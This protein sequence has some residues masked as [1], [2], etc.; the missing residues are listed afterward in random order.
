M[1]QHSEERAT[2][3]EATV[4]RGFTVLRAASLTLPAEESIRDFRAPVAPGRDIRS[5]LFGGF[6]RCV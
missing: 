3:Y 6:A 2:A 5:L 4:S 1:E